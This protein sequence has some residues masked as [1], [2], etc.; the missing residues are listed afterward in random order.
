MSDE[1]DDNAPDQ[2]PLLHDIVYDESLP[3][4]APP[5]ARQ[6]RIRRDHSEHGPE[7]DPDTIDLFKTHDP[8]SSFRSETGQLVEDLVQ[9]YSREIIVRLRDELTQQL[10][11]LL[12]DLDEK[13]LLHDSQ[14]PKNKGEEPGES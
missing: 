1:K 13:N 3:L 10:N 14:Q 4:R 11:A 6:P 12:T 9:E 2:I 7:Y 8:T 5:K